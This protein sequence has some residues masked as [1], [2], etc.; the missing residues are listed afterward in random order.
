MGKPLAV[1]W[2]AHELPELRAGAASS[3]H[4]ELAIR[5]PI[6]PGHYRLSIDMVDESRFWFGELG[7][8]T[9]DVDVDVQP[10]IQD[11]DEVDARLGDAE[12][13][14]DWLAHVLEAHRE[15]YAVVG[16]SVEF[17][18]GFFRRRPHALA[19]YA[20]GTGRI[21][22][23]GHPLVCA[24]VIKGVDVEWTEVG[25]L[26]AAIPPPDE[27]SLYDGRAVTRLRRQGHERGRGGHTE[28]DHVREPRD[29]AEEQRVADRVDRG[30]EEIG[31][32][33]DVR[34]PVVVGGGTREVLHRV[35]DRRQEEP[36]QEQRADEVLD[37][38]E[39]D[40]RAR[41]GEGE[42]GHEQYEHS[43]ERDRDP[44]GRAHPW[45]H[46]EVD[47]EQRDQHDDERDEVRRDGREGDEL[48]RKAR[49]A[50]QRRGL[51]QAL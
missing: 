49:L 36:R 12:P 16:G 18:G 31:P 8:P 9:L 50:D 15:G 13:A 3:A 27:P 43:R 6:P 19:P 40:G 11:V 35:E 46:R 34:E 47:R 29:L 39:D 10:R 25:G 32:A 41:D 26:P 4:V 17:G 48:A 23:F 28:V 44:L 1:R 33:Q 14:A 37:V 7:S 42:P 21:P 24:S 5:S 22:S 38:P 45:K 51:E 20:P 30:R 2:R